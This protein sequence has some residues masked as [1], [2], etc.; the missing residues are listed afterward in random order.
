[1]TET[2]DAPAAQAPAKKRSGGLNSMLLADLKASGRLDSTLVIWMGEFGRTPT[3]KSNS[4]TAGRGHYPRAWTSVLFG[5]GVP[6]G[7]VIGKTDKDAAEV[8]DRPISGLDFLATVCM[9]LGIDY[10]RENQTSIGRPIRI[11]D[12][13]AKPIK[14]LLG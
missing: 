10:T 4:G 14:E 1:M 11:V 7:R 5:G 3:I 13:G 9:L 2:P 8:V 12:K 6:G